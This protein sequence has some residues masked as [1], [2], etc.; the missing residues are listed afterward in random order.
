MEFLGY[1]RGF[2]LGCSISW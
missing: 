1:F 2:C